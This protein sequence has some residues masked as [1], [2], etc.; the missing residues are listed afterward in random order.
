MGYN[1]YIYLYVS[2]VVVVQ[3]NI[4]FGSMKYSMNVSVQKQITDDVG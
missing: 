1:R 4:C 2:V 3:L